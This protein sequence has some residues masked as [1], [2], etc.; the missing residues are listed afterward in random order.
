MH[1]PSSPNKLP[2]DITETVRR[3][4][5]EDLGSGDITATLIPEHKHAQGCI[6][7]KDTGSNDKRAAL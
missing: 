5:I 2:E 7:S 6:V 1:I 4:L 3:A